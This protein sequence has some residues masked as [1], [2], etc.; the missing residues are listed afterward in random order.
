MFVFY[1]ID[2]D[3]LIFLSELG[4]HL[5]PHLSSLFSS[6]GRHCDMHGQLELDEEQQLLSF[7][8]PGR[9]R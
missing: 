4:L 5:T 1:N 8:S 6:S 9:C 3:L 7:A 2:Q